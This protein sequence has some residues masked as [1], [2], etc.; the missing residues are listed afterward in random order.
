[1]LR[2]QSLSQ[3]ISY[4]NDPKSNVPD[5]LPPI[6]DTYNKLSI[7]QV[8]LF[9]CKWLWISWLNDILPSQLGLSILFETNVGCK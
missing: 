9:F 5:D 3:T 4:A 6:E 8:H 1:M 7:F 2:A